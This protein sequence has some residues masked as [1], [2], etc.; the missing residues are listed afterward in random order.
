LSVHQ[1]ARA[2][3]RGVARD[4]NRHEQAER[5]ERERAFHVASGLEQREYGAIGKR[6]ASAAK[7]NRLTRRTGAFL[8]ARLSLT[9]PVAPRRG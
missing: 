5:K 7:V 3:R 1:N 9:S 6:G 4:E 2:G 8:A